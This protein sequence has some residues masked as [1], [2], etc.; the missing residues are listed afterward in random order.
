MPDT[1]MNVT[2]GLGADMMIAAIEAWTCRRCASTNY[3]TPLWPH[4]IT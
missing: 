2:A 1:L 4:R 3:P